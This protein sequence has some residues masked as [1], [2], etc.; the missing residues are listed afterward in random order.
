MGRRRRGGGEA[1]GCA[2]VTIDRRA[3]TLLEPFQTSVDEIES[4]KREVEKALKAKTD[5]LDELRDRLTWSICLFEA[6]YRLADLGF[7]ADRLRLTVSSRPRSEAAAEDSGD[8]QEAD[9]GD[10]EPA[11][12]SGWSDSASDG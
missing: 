6:I 4:Q 5:L 2:S 1:L 11:A 12:F 3:L 9:T 7:H 8:G 10:T